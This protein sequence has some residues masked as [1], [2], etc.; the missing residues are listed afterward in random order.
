M[1]T[2]IHVSH[3]GLTEIDDNPNSIL[4]LGSLAACKRMAFAHGCELKGPEFKRMG[5]GKDNVN[6]N[7]ITAWNLEDQKGRHSLI[8]RDRDGWVLI[9]NK[10]TWDNE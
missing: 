7:I 3:L 9:L 4:F 8:Q 1:S 2:Q 10:E 6:Q 5:M